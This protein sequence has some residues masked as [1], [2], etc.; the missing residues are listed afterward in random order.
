MAI[1]SCAVLLVED[2]SLNQELLD[3]SL[4]A[5]GFEVQIDGN[6]HEALAVLP[7]WHP[8]AIVLDLEMPVMDG[9]SFRL[10]Q[11]RALELA[12]IP[13]I[14]LSDGAKLEKQAAQLE[15]TATLRMPCDPD[16]LVAVIRQA[17]RDRR[18]MAGIRQVATRDA[19]P[20]AARPRQATTVG[21]T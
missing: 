17:V 20:V 7:A 14:V 8:D 21:T 1:C 12:D 18:A 9:T 19:H 3:D 6:G 16:R 10:A 4:N 13:M 5:A 11:R 15:A 2:D